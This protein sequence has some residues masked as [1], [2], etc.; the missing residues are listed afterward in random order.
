M[1]K[2]ILK[3]ALYFILI[4]LAL[5]VLVR[6]FHLAKDTP[7]RY[8]DEF[9]VEKWKPNQEGFSVTGNR[10]QNFSEFHINDKGFNSYREFK[11]TKEGYEIALVGDSF[12]EGFHQ[13]YYNSI[14]KKIETIFKDTVSV[15][16]YGYAGYDFADQLHLI[17]K[18][19]RDFENIDLVI[20]GL[21]FTNDLDRSKYEV[22]TSRLALESPLNRS[23]KKIKLLVYLKNIGA[24]NP[25][26]KFFSNIKE[27][28]LVKRNTNKKEKD[29]T[30]HIED[31]N[32]K[33]DNFKSLIDLYGFDKSNYYLLIEENKTPQQF[34]KYLTDNKFKYIPIGEKLN[35]SSKN[36]TLIYD[37][38]WNNNGREIVA[39][40]IS[41]VVKKL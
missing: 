24:L 32:K 17:N 8:V 39:N 26:T 18:Y 15:Y 2:L 23:L 38:H 29:S 6:V 27:S 3:F 25:I 40:E 35:S 19:S 16:E 37:K 10:R 33:I 5:E 30:D 7:S 22:M 14:G 20:L 31:I 21:K 41:K 11:P 36:T 34:L 13:N 9:E 4:L 1:K 12:I 28:L